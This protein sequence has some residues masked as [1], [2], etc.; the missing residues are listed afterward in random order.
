MSS[1][2][3][4]ELHDK[5]LDVV[6][7]FDSFCKEHGVRYYMMGGTALG[8]VRHKGFI[9]WDDDFDVF[10]DYSNYKKFLDVAKI[11]LNRELFYLQLED[12]DEWPLF[13]SKLRMNNTTYIEKDV[14]GRKMHHG[15][16][17]DIMC[18]NNA[19]DNIFLRRLQYISARALSIAALGRKGYITASKLKKLTIFGANVIL[20]GW[21]KNSLLRFVRSLNSKDTKCIGHFFG[22]AAFT[23][24]SFPKSFLAQ[25]VYMSFENLKLPV[26]QNYDGYLSTR[27][28]C[29]YMAPPSE[30]VKA[31]FP[32]HAYIVDVNQSY[33][34][35]QSEKK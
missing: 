5:I 10:M 34:V 25:P 26:P 16:F 12:T 14:L 11:H 28:G 1:F 32:S 9:P 8:A 29:D 15:V 7:Y 18:L 2:D 35:Y 21:V 20:R 3:M 27:F 31:L 17:I 30:E 13:F 6:C 23:K 4:K 24:T 22:R 19:S 33:E